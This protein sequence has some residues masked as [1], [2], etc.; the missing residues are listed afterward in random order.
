MPPPSTP[1]RAQI[2]RAQLEMKE[3]ER[4][5]RDLERVREVVMRKIVD[6]RARDKEIMTAIIKELVESNRATEEE[7]QK[8]LVAFAV[9]QQKAPRF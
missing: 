7:G 1:T 3:R 4:R 9:Y 2:H 6:L 5:I 8:A